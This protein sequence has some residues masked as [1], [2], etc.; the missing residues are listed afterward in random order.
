MVEDDPDLSALVGEALEALG[1]TTAANSI[2]AA[3]SA[4]AEQSPDVVVLDVMLPDGN[5]LDLVTELQGGQ[6]V[7]VPVLVLTG[8]GSGDQ[9]VRGFDAGADD[10]LLKPFDLEELRV[11][12]R[13]LL[14]MRHVEQTLADHNLSLEQANRAATILLDTARALTALGDQE[15]VLRGALT[16]LPDLFGADRAAI[17]LT[18]LDQDPAQVWGLEVR[19]NDA[20]RRMSGHL[21]PDFTAVPFDERGLLVVEDLHQAALPAE[22]VD[23]AELRS[24]I[25]ATIARGQERLGALLIGYETP[26]RHSTQTL[27]VVQGLANQLAI[28]IENARRYEQL[29]EAALT[30][31][32]TG[33]HNMRSFRST[34]EAEL[35]RA[36]RR[37]HDNNTE[38]PLSVLMMDLNKFKQYNDSYG[39]PIGDEALRRFGE[40]IRSGL[41]QYDTLARYGGDEFIV[42]LP[43]TGAAAAHLLAERLRRRVTDSA[44]RLGDGI[45]VRFSC[46]VGVA[47]YPIDGANVDDLVRIADDALYADKRRSGDGHPALADQPA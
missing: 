21:H 23:A 8:L 14:R 36:Q 24:L 40:L 28:A 37:R 32:A 47:T 31:S 38:E 43:A 4:F 26:Q 20:P 19:G 9:K 17:W 3:R 34:L 11:R 1:T 5:G 33:L 7:H 12:V 27:D 6:A 42:L 2:A 22:A 25:L 45:N 29:Q 46:A 44:V 30:D 18:S 10:Y 41:R 15:T 35:S 13:A 39:H 16:L